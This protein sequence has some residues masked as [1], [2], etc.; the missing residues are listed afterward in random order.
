M[1][2]SSPF[3]DAERRIAWSG[4]GFGRGLLAVLLGCS[5]FLMSCRGGGFLGCN[6]VVAF[7]L[8]GDSLNTTFN[9]EEV[10]NYL[11]FINDPFSGVSF[12]ELVVDAFAADGSQFRL[13]VQDFRPDGP[14]DCVTPEPYYANFT[15]NY[16]VPAV[17]FACNGFT[18]EY[19][20][21]DGNL[22][23][24]T[25]STGQ[26]V[27]GGCEDGRVNGTFSFDVESFDTGD[28][29]SIGSGSFSVCFGLL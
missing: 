2:C 5:M 15:L 9:T 13:V 6:N 24:Q 1:P 21:A 11:S 3:T 4:L 19:T 8:E 16:C 17:P 26:L 25:G 23:F 14:L 28:R 10:A 29:G 22:Y 12:F 7:Q 18:A 20:D 27:I